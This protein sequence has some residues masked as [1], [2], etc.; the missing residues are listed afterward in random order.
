MI[1]PSILREDDG[2]ALGAPKA[3]RH[4]P[5][6]EIQALLQEYVAEAGLP[7]VR[8]TPKV[9]WDPDHCS[10]IAREFE[11]LE[12]RDGSAQVRAAYQALTDEVRAQYELLASHIDFE[13]YGDGDPVPYRDSEDMMDDVRDR[14]HLW[15]YSGGEDHALLTREANFMFRAVHDVF[16]HA[17]QGWSFGAGGEENA[18]VEHSK[19]FSP[20]ARAA[21]TTETRGQNS[22]VNCG[23]HAGLPPKERPYA[24]Q[25]AALLPEELWLHPVVE[26]AYRDAPEFL[27]A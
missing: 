20:L 16:G 4:K 2:Y 12:F 5:N 18:W 27:Y 23:P 1:R 26:K 24:E 17:A 21:L 8:T 13:P 25:K 22:W 14:R 19:A 10:L 6:P 15:V 9:A 11:G 7:P 3:L